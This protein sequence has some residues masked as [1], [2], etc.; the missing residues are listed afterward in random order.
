MLWI[1]NCRQPTSELEFLLELSTLNYDTC[2][3]CEN[4]IFNIIF[5]VRTSVLTLLLKTCKALNG[6]LCADVPLRNY[7][8][9]HSLSLLLEKFG[10]SMQCSQCRWWS[11]C[12]K[13]STP[14][15]QML[16]CDLAAAVFY[17]WDGVLEGCRCV[18]NTS[19]NS[20][21]RCR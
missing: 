1:T 20:I 11:I 8:L 21:F 14:L 18:Y 4:V 6:L 12:F 5:T 19:I 16:R 15:A 7:S 17:L 10:W 13:P 3:N 2:A 9:T